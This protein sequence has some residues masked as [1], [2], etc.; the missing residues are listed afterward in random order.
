LKFGLKLYLAAYLAVSAHIGYDFFQNNSPRIERGEIVQQLKIQKYKLNVEGKEK[1]LILAGECHNYS[2][3]E[4]DLAHKLIEENKYFANEVGNDTFENIPFWSNAYGF[5]VALPMVPSYIYGRLGDGRTYNSISRVAR[6][7]GYTVFTLEK[8]DSFSQMSLKEKSNMFSAAVLS[9]FIAPLAYYNGK[10][11]KTYDEFNDQIDFL[12][13]S[14]KIRDKAMAEEIINILK[15]DEIDKLLAS[16]GRA[17]LKGV[18]SNLSKQVELQ[19][20]N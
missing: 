7:K 10:N 17:H 9:M 3:K 13:E 8:K 11:E 20:I 2:K 1:Q 16:F 14:T 5:L 12:S 15:K 19:E 18:I 4:H 6:E